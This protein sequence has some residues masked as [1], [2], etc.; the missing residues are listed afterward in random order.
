MSPDA[1]P[2]AQR[3]MLGLLVLLTSELEREHSEAWSL[4]IFPHWFMLCPALSC[5][6]RAA[7]RVPSSNAYPLDWTDYGPSVCGSH[8]IPL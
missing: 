7:V 8:G 4:G 5:S 3:G 6:Y 1:L 2:L